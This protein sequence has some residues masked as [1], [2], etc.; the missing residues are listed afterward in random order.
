MAKKQKSPAEEP[1]PLS[2]LA[3]ARLVKNHCDNEISRHDK[4]PN[5]WWNVTHSSYYLFSNFE[6]VHHIPP[7][8]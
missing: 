2:D 4:M 7:R 1:T 8:K 6:A 3:A 5:F